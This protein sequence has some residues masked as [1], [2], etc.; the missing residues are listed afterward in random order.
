MD[1]KTGLPI[2]LI[3]Y[4][5]KTGNTKKMAE[6]I[7]QGAKEY[8]QIEV[9]LKTAEEATN[10]DLV[11]AECIVL[12]SPTYFRLPAWPLKKFIDESIDVYEKLHTKKGAVFSSAGDDDSGAYCIEALKN[13]LEEHGIKIIA[14]GLLIE[15]DPTE[16]EIEK[17]KQFGSTI[18]EQL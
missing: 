18:A 15:E 14:D 4:Y 1:Q 11:K 3:V 9:V 8:G 10:D 16:E 6:A 13:I 17:C 5:S 12:G 2:L 7:S